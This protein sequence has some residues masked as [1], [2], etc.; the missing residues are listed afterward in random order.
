MS[1]PLENS[2][3][4][5]FSKGGSSKDGYRI[6]YLNPWAAA[7]ENQA[8]ASLQQAARAIG[9]EMIHCT[10]SDDVMEAGLDFVLAVAS[11][12]PKLTSVPT[13]GNIHEARSRFWETISYFH[14]LLSYDGYLT[15]SDTLVRFLKAFC[16]GLHRS[17]RVGTFYI[18]P[19]ISQFSSDIVTAARAGKLR[20]CYFGTNWDLRARALFL[21]LVQREY[22]RV[23]GPEKSWTYLNG[24]GF[25]G[26]LPFDG[27]SVQKT[28]AQFGVGLVLLSK[29]HALD[30]IITNRLFEI[31]SV[32]AVAICPDIPWVKKYFGETVYYYPTWGSHIEIAARI[33]QIMAQIG[34]DPEAAAARG[35]AARAIFES[36]FS[37]EVLIANSVNYFETWQDER[38][39]RV[40][41]HQD[42][43]VDVIVRTGGRSLEILSRALDSIDAQTAGHIRVVLVRYAPQDV[44]PI[45]DKAWARIASFEV[46]DCLGGGRAATLCSGLKVLRSDY[47]A[48]LDDDD[49]WLDNHLETLLAAVADPSQP[50]VLAFS[51]IIECSAG[52]APGQE[53]RRVRN[54]DAVS[55]SIQDILGRF[56]MHTFLAPR[57]MAAPVD[58]DDWGMATAED[59]ALIGQLLRGAEV[60][61]THRPTA[62]QVI[63]EDG[64]SDFV[65]RPD[66]ADDVFEAFLRIG[67]GMERVEQALPSPT[68]SFWETLGRLMRA[69]QASRAQVIP[70]HTALLAWENGVAAA[71]LSERAD[72]RARAGALEGRLLK[73]GAAKLVEDR[74]Q[75]VVQIPLGER[76]GVGLAMPIDDL[77]ADG[78]RWIV[79]ELTGAVHPVCVGAV[80]LATG[81]FAA[82]MV[83]LAGLENLE[84]WLRL[85]GP[86]DT[87]IV[88]AWEHPLDKPLQLRRISSVQGPASPDSAL[89]ATASPNGAQI[90]IADEADQEA[91][92]ARRGQGLAA[93]VA[94]KRR[95]YIEH[96]SRPV[97]RTSGA[98][99][100]LADCFDLEVR[101]IPLDLDRLF[102]SGAEISLQDGNEVRI[103][104]TSEAAAWAYLLQTD[105]DK[106]LFEGRQWLVVETGD[107]SDDFAIALLNK[108]KSVFTARVQTPKH[109]DSLE[110]WLDIEAPEDVSR[111]V[112]H[113][114]ETPLS[115]PL[116]LKSISVVREA[117]LALADAQVQRSTKRF[118]WLNF[119][120]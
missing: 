67:P 46:V 47:F 87:L 50:N 33:D 111:L 84:I 68:A 112:L 106:Y 65:N 32:G 7:A 70:A 105:I 81:R 55:G 4:A 88:Q 85:E 107:V 37:G 22:M 13:F 102:V 113:H 96:A 54:L 52:V 10:T 12:Q 100:P 120:A 6:G 74:G 69:S 8:F 98:T 29:E 75:H 109:K 18:S 44:Q 26:P 9:H 73:G 51:G 119:K 80:D 104:F 92:E 14:N 45:L 16:A 58:L 89:P 76:W 114:W 53:R 79:V 62:V 91:E 11:T 117:P 20:V 72:C 43:T 25:H 108:A 116:V 56:G 30:D 23:H 115:S 36:Q 3:S 99:T 34:A 28:Y 5:A 93:Y 82:R 38:R 24:R 42:K 1:G 40:E 35:A 48:V 118:G 57:A 61:F 63:G 27:E 95:W 49:Y 59:S 78:P 71:P 2:L 60:R 86:A 31:T 83:T 64:Q 110:V 19:Q 90:E 94:A 39:I 66:R 15:I 21:T 97:L 101:K 17:A 103:D 77:V 41:P